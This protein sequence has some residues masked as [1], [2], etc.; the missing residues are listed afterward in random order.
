MG[1]MTG[2]KALLFENLNFSRGGYGEF[3]GFEDAP[4][5]LNDLNEKS[6]L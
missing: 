1:T 3:S 4:Y 5:Y 2:K 6:K